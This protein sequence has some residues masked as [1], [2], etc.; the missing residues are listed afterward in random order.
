MDT[1]ELKNKIATVALTE[2]EVKMMSIMAQY[3]IDELPSDEPGTKQFSDQ[4][5]ELACR[6]DIH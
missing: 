4:L 5:R 3:W 2:A 1:I 6:F